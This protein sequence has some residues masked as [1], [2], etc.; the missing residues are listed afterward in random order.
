RPAARARCR[1]TAFAA[2]P[3]ARSTSP[4][5]S[6]WASGP[7]SFT[8]RASTP[9]SWASTFEPSPIA[10]TSTRLSCAHASTSCSSSIDSGR[11]NHRA[12][13]PV[14]IVVWRA[15]G[16]FS[17]TD[18][19][20]SGEQA[21]GAVHVAGAEHEQDVAPARTAQEPLRTGVDRRRPA[22]EHTA[23]GQRVDDELPGD[24][25][26]RLLAR[27]IDVGHRDVVR[28]RERTSELVGEVPRAREE[29]RLEEH[30]QC[31]AGKPLACSG[32][33]GRDLRRGMR[34][35]VDDGVAGELAHLEA[36]PG[37]GE[38]CEH[39]LR[40]RPIDTGQL[41][42]GERAA[43]VRAIVVAGKRERSVERRYVANDVLNAGEPALELVLEL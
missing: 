26:H 14:P 42:R 27:R 29:V 6:T 37:P 31:P 17:S 19:N 34:V 38:R 35:V 1:H 8:T 22:G 39:G 9:S 43:R 24:T 10:S 32:D 11:A 2:P 16:T 23:V 33:R 20:L 36:P 4:S 12:G 40:R 13:P 7:A 3:P 15:S 21:D 41:E 5:S 25:R 30:A 28:G 18:P